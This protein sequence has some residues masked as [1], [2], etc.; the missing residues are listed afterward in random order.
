MHQQS[1]HYNKQCSIELGS[2]VQA[3]T[4]PNPQNTQHAGTIDCIYL[5]YVHNEQG[6]HQLLDLRAGRMI[7]RRTVTV[8]PIY[9]NIINFVSYNCIKGSDVRRTK[10]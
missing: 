3:H 4:E 10:D 7:E 8:V 9:Q 1:L 6:G 5:R 2:Y